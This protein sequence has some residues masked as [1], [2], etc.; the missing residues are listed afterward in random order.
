MKRFCTLFLILATLLSGLLS[1]PGGKIFAVGIGLAPRCFFIR[2]TLVVWRAQSG[3][4]PLTP[5]PQNKKR[6]NAD[7]CI[8][9]LLVSILSGSV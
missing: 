9:A 3:T 1:H 5:C 4:K 6:R 8:A 7:L 2:R